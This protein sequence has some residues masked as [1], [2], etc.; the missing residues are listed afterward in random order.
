MSSFEA[1]RDMDVDFKSTALF[2]KKEGIVLFAATFPKG[3]SSESHASVR[4]FAPAV[5]VPEDPFT[6]SIQGGLTAYLY[7]LGMLPSGQST[8]RFEQGHFIGRPGRAAIDI[9][10]WEPFHAELKAEARLV[11]STELKLD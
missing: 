1:L 10:N 6:G 8:F 7:R 9:K 2:G 3:F 5:G 4:G 11:F